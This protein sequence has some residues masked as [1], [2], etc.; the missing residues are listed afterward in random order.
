MLY[1]VL[2][3]ITGTPGYE[4][5]DL[6]DGERLPDVERLLALKAIAPHG[7][8]DEIPHPPAAEQPEDDDA[9]QMIEELEEECKLAAEVQGQMQEMIDA[10]N[11]EIAGLRDALKARDAEIS[12]LKADLDTA[13]APAAV[14]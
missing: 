3:T 9:A 13:T 6:V 14:V 12:Q 1:R 2:H 5:D 10:K 4:P 7:P 8:A 11:A